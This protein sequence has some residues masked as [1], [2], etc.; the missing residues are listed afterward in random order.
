MKYNLDEMREA[1]L[2]AVRLCDG[3]QRLTGLPFRPRELQPIFDGWRM[4]SDLGAELERL[5]E[6]NGRL[7]SCNKELLYDNEQKF[8]ELQRLQK[9]E[10]K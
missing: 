7:D 10:G 2:S 6:E 9:L 4:I 5:R 8:A 1:M 3:I